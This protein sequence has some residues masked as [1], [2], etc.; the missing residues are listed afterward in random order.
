MHRV[1]SSSVRLPHGVRDY[2][3]EAAAERRRIAESL[4]GEFERWGYRRIVTPA[5][6]YE[7]VLARGLG[8]EAQAQAVRFVEPGTGEVVMLRPDIT[9]QISRLV[10]TRLADEP[11]PIRLAY[12]G[13][14]VRL[15]EGGQREVFQAGVELI[16]APAPTGDVEVIAL[17]AAALAGVGIARYT[18]DLGE[19][20]IARAALDGLGPEAAALREAIARK[21]VD[22]VVVQARALGLPAWRRRLV[23]ALPSLYG[24]PEV[25]DR[26][27]RLVDG[28]AGKAARAGL[29]A[30]AVVIE[31]LGALGLAEHLS[32][33][34]GE[35]RGFDYYTGVRMQ[36]FAPGVG[37]AL[38]SG[39]RYDG[40]LGRYGRS[41]SAA[42]FAIDVEGVAQALPVAGAAA[43]SGVYLAGEADARGQLAAALRR[44][45]L[46]V[47]EELASPLPADGVL[48]TSAR[49]LG[50]AHVM[51]VLPA[52]R[53][54][55]LLDAATGVTARLAAAEV[56][57]LLAGNVAGTAGGTVALDALVSPR[58][59]VASPAGRTGRR[60]EQSGR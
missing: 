46:R 19:A 26:A 47:V 38:L 22:E 3:P 29:G 32:V 35:V 60:S 34:L 59:A 55:R 10:A 7:A 31:R 4:L 5:F 50:A 23:E 2:L 13:A 56:A 14:V 54:A 28:G 27:A 45:G 53:G 52:G 15:S 42:G 25:I 43:P 16:D 51:V 33:D 20:S 37:G 11:G 39:G 58:Y 24:G 18:L 41:A 40:L 36:G 1:T 9:P 6:E 49:R 8:P 21:H 17:A 30:L 44:A 57:A 12:E 48:A